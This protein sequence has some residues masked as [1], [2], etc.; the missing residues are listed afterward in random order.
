MYSSSQSTGKEMTLPSSQDQIQAQDQAKPSDKDLNFRAMEARYQRQLEQERQARLQAEER[1]ANYERERSK[2]ITSQEEEEDDAPYI[3]RRAL[4]KELS[5]FTE[6]FSKTVDQKAEEK[7]RFY[8]EKE[9]EA[10]Y[11]KQNNDFNEI[12]SPDMIQK[13]AEKYPDIAEP[14]LEMPHSFARQK[15]VYQ[16][17]KALGLHRPAEP[18]NNIQDTIDRNK[19]NPFYHPSSVNSPPYAGQQAD[20]SESGQQAAY[21]KMQELIA[22]RKAF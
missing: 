2:P 4:K 8:V 12:M 19:K 3:D 18:K 15:L 17:I 20:F 11:L 13:F 10:N 21:K 22:K 9:R 6:N 1:A 16:N 5:R 14:I 7:A